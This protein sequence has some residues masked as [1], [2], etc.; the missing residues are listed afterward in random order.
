MAG[1]VREGVM[2]YWLEEKKVDGGL[3]DHW[4]P[5][6]Q[7]KAIGDYAYPATLDTDI[8]YREMS[9]IDDDTAPYGKQGRGRGGRYWMRLMQPGLNAPWEPAKQGDSLIVVES[10]E[11]PAK[12]WC[13]LGVTLCASKYPKTKWAEIVPPKEPG[14]ATPPIDA[15]SKVTGTCGDCR[16]SGM[17]AR[18]ADGAIIAVMRCYVGFH[19]SDVH[20]NHV[21]ESWKPTPADATPKAKSTPANPVFT[22]SPGR[23]DGFSAHYDGDLHIAPDDKAEPES[24]KVGQVYCKHA[25]QVGRTAMLSAT[26]PGANAI[27]K[28]ASAPTSEFRVLG[29]GKMTFDEWLNSGP[30]APAPIVARKAH[31][32]KCGRIVPDDAIDAYRKVWRER[33]WWT[34]VLDVVFRLW[35]TVCCPHCGQWFSLK[36]LVYRDVI[37]APEIERRITDARQTAI[38]SC[39]SKMADTRRDIGSLKYELKAE[40]A[41]RKLRDDMLSDHIK[42]LEYSAGPKADDVTLC[43][44]KGR[45]DTLETSNTQNGWLI[46]V[47]TDWAKGIQKRVAKLERGKRGKGAGR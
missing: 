9:L 35:N 47:Q 3:V 28:Q 38:A 27:W 19:P 30:T 16:H 11:D 17:I 42:L 29:G 22:Y 34:H 13:G 23:Y 44:L 32:P 8:R 31:C 10:I 6:G 26:P 39:N 40:L 5:T 37:N 18:L 45:L 41:N 15:P 25:M 4:E 33:T 24:L 43:D 20:E 7:V 14:T 1:Q 36:R 2:R 12:S 21:C 46:T